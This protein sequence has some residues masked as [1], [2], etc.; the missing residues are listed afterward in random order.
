MAVL[1]VEF[2]RKFAL[3]SLIILWLTD[4]FLLSICLSRHQKI[5]AHGFSM[6]EVERLRLAA[7]YPKSEA[8]NDTVKSLSRSSPDI[9]PDSESEDQLAI[10][11]DR[12]DSIQQAVLAGAQVW[13][14]VYSAGIDVRDEP[15]HSAQRS[16][17]VA[18]NNFKILRWCDSLIYICQGIDRGQVALVTEQ[19]VQEDNTYLRLDPRDVLGQGQYS[20]LSVLHLIYWRSSPFEHFLK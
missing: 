5:G 9:Q 20:L 8:R 3:I 10:S 14:C 17:K 4:I 18:Q 13:K 12:M 15:H 1:S 11:E 6:E 2:M 19:L 16:G 7:N